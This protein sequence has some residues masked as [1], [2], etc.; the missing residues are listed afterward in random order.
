MT[1]TKRIFIEETTSGPTGSG[2]RE[3]WEPTAEEMRELGWVPKG[4]VRLDIGPNTEALIAAGHRVVAA[5]ESEALRVVE[6]SHIE[7]TTP[8]TL[9]RLNGIVRPCPLHT[10]AMVTLCGACNAWNER[11]KAAE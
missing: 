9:D 3:V 11:D 10:N 1:T 2:T 5:V 8:E 7:T 4:T 6:K